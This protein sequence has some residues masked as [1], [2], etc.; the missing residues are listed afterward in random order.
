MGPLNEA[1]Q[2]GQQQID[3]TL[4]RLCFTISTSLACVQGNSALGVLLKRRKCNV[5]K[6]FTNKY[7]PRLE[8]FQKEVDSVLDDLGTI[9][10]GQM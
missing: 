5:M 1:R 9:F 8:Y 4:E 2:E 6:S 7:Q 3:N 10:T